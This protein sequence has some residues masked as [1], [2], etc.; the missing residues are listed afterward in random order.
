M[1]ESSFIEK[2]SSTRAWLPSIHGGGDAGGGGLVGLLDNLL[3]KLGR[4]TE[5]GG[6]IEMLPGIQT[7]G[8]NV[9]PS[10]VHFP[11]A[12]LTVFFLLELLGTLLRREKLRQAASAM[13][14]CGALGAAAAAA[15]GLYAASFVPH[16][17][18]VHEIMEWHERLGF[19]VTGL[20]L[21]LSLW[22]WLA[23]SVFVGMAK[24]LHLLLATIMMACM[25]F[26][27]DLGGLMVYGH[28]VAVRKLQDANANV[29]HQHHGDTR[30]AES[31]GL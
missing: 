6:G 25:V 2:L 18:E 29:Q 7:L 15:A 16:S 3:E 31:S 1:F 17:Q 24:A 23:K 5:P 4:A 12:L 22:R 27:A 20:A 30:P 21:I 28:G 11:I 13:L 26:G 9:H 8:P 10:L 19:T 14:Y